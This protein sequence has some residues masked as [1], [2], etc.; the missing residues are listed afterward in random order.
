MEEP[1]KKGKKVSVQTYGHTGARNERSLM[2]II[3]VQVKVKGDKVMQTY[4]FLDPGSLAIF[5]SEH[6]M[7]E[8]NLSGKRVKI[9]LRTM[10]QEQSVSCNI[11]DGLNQWYKRQPF[12]LFTHSRRCLLT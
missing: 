6:L 7:K 4:A 11:I 1:E 2:P 3:P 12:L 9:L 10:G 8:L 5:C